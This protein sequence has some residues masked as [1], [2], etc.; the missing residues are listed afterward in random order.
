MQGQGSVPAPLECRQPGRHIAPRT[1]LKGT[2]RRA[3]EARRAS[4]NSLACDGARSA[5]LAR[6]SLDRRACE[7]PHFNGRRGTAYP[8]GSGDAGALLGEDSQEGVCV[9]RSSG[10][11]VARWPKHST[12]AS[13]GYRVLSC[14][15]GS[16]G[17]L[18][19]RLTAGESGAKGSERGGRSAQRRAHQG[20]PSM[21]VGQSI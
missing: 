20:T 6:G 3:Q 11:Q 16:R 2:L 1:R 4:S 19:S 17:A 15:A 13:R 10:V 5:F 18:A 12:V 14:R 9:G 21:K 7:Q 8:G